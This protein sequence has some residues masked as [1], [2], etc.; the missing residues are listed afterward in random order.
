LIIEKKLGLADVFD[1]VANMKDFFWQRSVLVTVGSTV[2][3]I[4]SGFVIANASTVVKEVPV[5]DE[6]TL[7]TNVASSNL[8]ASVLDPLNALVNPFEDGNT[9]NGRGSDYGFAGVI[10]HPAEKSIDLFWI[11]DIE[12]RAQAILDSAPAELKIFV[13]PA[14]YRLSEML[15]AVEKVVGLKSGPS[16][17]LDYLILSAGPEADG[18]GIW[19]EYEGDAEAESI[20]KICSIIAKIAVTSATVGEPLQG[21]VG[22]KP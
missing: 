18:S 14:R 17:S 15:D 2:A 21:L 13:H 22:K 7:N 1:S 3:L 16:D 6:L 5:S 9:P 4:L 10:E 19:I 20:A 8:I 12:P 11:G